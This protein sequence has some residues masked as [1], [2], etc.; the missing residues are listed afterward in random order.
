VSDPL[1]PVSIALSV[2]A[3]LDALGIFYTVGGSLASSKA[4]DPRSTLDVDFVVALKEAQLD[5]LVAALE[6]DFYV[7]REGLARA[8]RDRSSANIVHNAGQVK[9]DLFIAGGTPLDE[10]QLARRRAVI[11][12]DGRR[13]YMHPPE[14]ILLQKLR[15]FRM[16]GE[17]SDRQWRDIQGIVR[18][19]GKRLDRPYLERSAP[20]IG[21]TDLLA[22]ALADG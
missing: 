10:Q 6:P 20:L 15:W 4:G 2:G 12:A 19:Q 17:V 13:L 21:V 11:F 18:T 16:G 3:I 5:E 7:N 8:V 14:D 1:E 9:V 22:R